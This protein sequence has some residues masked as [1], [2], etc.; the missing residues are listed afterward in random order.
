MKRQGFAGSI[1]VDVLN[2]H[3]VAAVSLGR[4]ELEISVLVEVAIRNRR[5]ERDTPNA[6]RQWILLPKWSKFSRVHRRADFSA[7][8]SV[9]G[10]PMPGRKTLNSSP[11]SLP[12]K[13]VSR[14]SSRI[15]RAIILNASSP[16]SCPKLSLTA[17]K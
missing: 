1:L 9:L 16:C 7:I 3:S 12:T 2:F 4:I 14:T 5:F 11:P 10:W 6:H 17:L 15:L 13:S 8:I